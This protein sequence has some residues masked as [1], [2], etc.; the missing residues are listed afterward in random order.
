MSLSVFET[1]QLP[2]MSNTRLVAGSEGLQNI[3][4]WVTVVEVIDDINRLQEGEFLI[5]TG[6]GLLESEQKRNQFR[7][8]LSMKKLSGVALYTGFYLH[9]IPQCFIDSANENDL[10]LI[11]IPT[12]INFSQI[13]KVVLQQI[14]NSQMELM[15][16]SLNIHNELTKM[17]LSNQGISTITK[18]LSSLIDG[19]VIIYNDISE[20]EYNYIIHDFIKLETN[21]LNFEDS[22]LTIQQRLDDFMKLQKPIHLEEK[23]LKFM[24]CPIIANDTNY[25][26]IMGIK[27][28]ENWREM[29]NIA[30]EHAATVYAIEYLKQAA[31]E[32]TQIRLQ[33]EFLEEVINKNFKNSSIAL[34]RGKRLGYNLSLNQS[35]FYI[36]IE[37]S[38]KKSY[39]LKESFNQLYQIT[40]K[41]LNKKNKQ[42]ILRTK[43]DSLI[44]LTEIDGN[45]SKAKRDY[46][47]QLAKNIELKWEKI[48]PNTKLKIGIGKTYNDINKL[49]QSAR[50]AEYAI[51]L[52]NLLLKPKPIVH[53]D[54]LGLYHLL[55]QMKESD[56]N[57]FQFY[58]ENLGAL[59][60]N[61][62]HGIDLIFTLETY[63]TNNQSIQTT[64][65]ELFIHRH[66]LKYRLNQIEKKT[67]LSLS[68]ADNRMKLQLAIMAY[69][70]LNYSEG[71]KS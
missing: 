19:T 36:K 22:E 21:K 63:L 7:Q 14:V 42:F 49:G 69:K 60:T 1:L 5:T 33:G 3:I 44:L 32:E 57:L 13:T 56:I 20:I 51:N 61:S 66:T 54:D 71:F 18:T 15:E 40:Q 27:E 31:V 8:L 67:G 59:I 65:S 48:F 2:V 6:F 9:E 24:V 62:T 30:I 38:M 45:D 58:Q 70:L 46:S 41:I 11:E 64:A 39:S 29:D 50:E 17:V 26:F 47:I 25:G 34:E 53:F 52:S 12:D 68:S 35:V 43:I 16:Y 55:I 4:K 10:P 37:D 28:T 23:N